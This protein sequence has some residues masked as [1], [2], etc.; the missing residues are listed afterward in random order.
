MT[1][2]GLEE[3]MP[4]RSVAC[5]LK[6]NFQVKRSNQNEKGGRGGHKRDWEPVQY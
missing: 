5:E 2:S 1:T 3:G 6:S 4:T